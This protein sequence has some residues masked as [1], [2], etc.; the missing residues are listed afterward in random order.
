[1]ITST[2]KFQNSDSLYFKSIEYAN[3]HNIKHVLL[4]IQNQ[5]KIMELNSLINEKEFD[6]NIIGVT[7]P[8]NEKMYIKEQGKMIQYVPH[9]ADGDEVRTA[10]TK[11]GI[12]LISGTLPF[13]GIVVPG[14]PVNPYEIIKQT[15]G[16]FSPGLQNVV[17]S[18]LMTT[19]QGVVLPSE[20]VIAM[21][22]SVSIEA[23]AANTRFLFHPL[24]GLKIHR[25][26]GVV[27]EKIE[28]ANSGE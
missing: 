26:L 17:Q 21:N 18:I 8:S 19:D 28:E 10:L 16:L 9:A 11:Q 14:A 6:V 1:M 4:F 22:N 5:E 27:E 3:E 25:I 23:S 24:D 2:Y 12:R 13:E 20:K 7:F 15:L